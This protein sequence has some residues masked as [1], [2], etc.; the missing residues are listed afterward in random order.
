MRIKDRKRE[1]RGGMEKMETMR[2]VEEEGGSKDSARARKKEEVES[3][4][5]PPPMR[6]QLDKTEVECRGRGRWLRWV[7]F[8]HACT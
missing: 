5:W 1:K 2:V 3:V 4:K 7:G 8:G 6:V